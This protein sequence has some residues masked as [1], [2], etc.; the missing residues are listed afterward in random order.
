[1][2][3]GLCS[4]V[5]LWLGQSIAFHHIGEKI[6]RISDSSSPITNSEEPFFL[7]QAWIILQGLQVDR[8]FHPSQN[9]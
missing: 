5:S 6:Q 2:E 7:Y 3:Y 9:T 1:R 4:S 8:A